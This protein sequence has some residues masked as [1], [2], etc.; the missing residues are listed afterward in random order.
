[1]SN[2]LQILPEDRPYQQPHITKIQ[3]RLSDIDFFGHV[4]AARI[5]EMVF[6]ARK[7]EMDEK[8]PNAEIYLKEENLGWVIAGIEIRYLRQLLRTD[9]VEIQTWTSKMREKECDAAFKIV[10]NGKKNAAEGVLH[11][12]L[13]AWP[14]GRSVK[15]PEELMALYNAGELPMG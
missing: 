11:F 10:K 4:H 3:T 7:M 1:M 13:V 15:M 5:I 6:T 8:F 9:T 14:S 12:T 2:D